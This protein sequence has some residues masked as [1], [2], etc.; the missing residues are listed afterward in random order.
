[1]HK[2]AGKDRRQSHR[3][4][5][6][7]TTAVTCQDDALV[8]GANLALSVLDISADGIRLMVRSPLEIGQKIKLDRGGIGYCRP[9]ELVGEVVW[10]LPTADGNWCVGAKF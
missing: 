1:M 7:P 8:V 9:I 6:R 2:P 4:R 3:R 5:P 10:S